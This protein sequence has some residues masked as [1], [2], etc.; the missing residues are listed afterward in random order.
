[1]SREA[2][3]VCDNHFEKPC[4][5]QTSTLGTSVPLVMQSL[6]NIQ[7]SIE[8]GVRKHGSRPTE[9]AEYTKRCMATG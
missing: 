2:N 6:Y 7:C 8:H 4:T 9:Y 5:Y 3:D 1:M